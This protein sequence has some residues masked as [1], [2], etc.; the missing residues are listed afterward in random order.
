MIERTMSS[1]H[2]TERVHMPPGVGRDRGKVHP[3]VG[4]CS[5]HELHQ[6]IFLAPRSPRTQRAPESFAAVAT[7]ARGHHTICQSATSDRG[8]IGEGGLH[9]LHARV[10]TEV[11]EFAA[12][13]RRRRAL[14]RW[15]GRSRE[16]RPGLTAGVVGFVG[17]HGRKR[18]RTFSPP[19]RGTWGLNKKPLRCGT[20]GAKVGQT[21]RTFA[22]R[23]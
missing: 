4:P 19:G 15:R 14:L 12:G 8:G 17:F 16:R 7:L 9:R 22:V 23:R 3:V 18:F 10:E 2:A 5:D 6:F 20:G 21:I 13:S 1:H 11:E